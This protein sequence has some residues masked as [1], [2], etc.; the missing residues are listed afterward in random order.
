MG[1]RII[2][3]SLIIAVVIIPIAW[4][5][6]LI[7]GNVLEPVIPL[8]QQWSGVIERTPIAEIPEAPAMMLHCQAIKFRDKEQQSIIACDHNRQAVVLYERKD[9]QWQEEIIAHGIPSAAHVDVGD[10]DGDGD[11]DLVIAVLGNLFPDENKVGK[12]VLLK[13]QDNIWSQHTLPFNLRRVADVEFADL[14]GDGDQDL[15]VAEFGH[16]HGSIQWLEC[17]GSMEYR[18]HILHRAPGSIHIISNDFDLDGDI[19]FACCVSQHDEEVYLFENDGHGGMQKHRIFKSANYDLGISGLAKGDID[20][21]GDLD[22]I[23]SCGDN[24]E[25]SFHYPQPYHGCYLLTNNGGLQFDCEKIADIPGCYGACVGDF[26]GDGDMDVAAVSV[27]NTWQNPYAAG[28][29]LIEQKSPGHFTTF[30]LVN[31]PIQMVSCDKIDMNDD[32]QDEI[33]TSCMHLHE[34]F[35]RYGSVDYWTV[36]K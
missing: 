25:N 10:L 23:I 30:R 33:I 34:P 36:N 28:L 9:Q 11:Q 27:I 13:Q 22:L 18:Q 6:K 15:I 8:H 14:D 29:Y 12:I 26:D 31:N 35:E 2:V 20:N 21:D 7:Q 3:C 24:F 5:K 32:G 4:P 19:D 1:A 16:H 17:V